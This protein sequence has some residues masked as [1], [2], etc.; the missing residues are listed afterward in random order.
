MHIL[1]VFESNLNIHLTAGALLTLVGGDVI[2]VTPADSGAGVPDEPDPI[3][4]A[5]GLKGLSYM[6]II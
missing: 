4:Y 1:L 6:H 5:I 3:T 2:S